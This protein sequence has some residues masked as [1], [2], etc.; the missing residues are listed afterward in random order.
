MSEVE[1]PP[2]AV[3]SAASS[4]MPQRRPSTEKF[5]ISV[6][7][8]KCEA[9]FLNNSRE[10]YDK[11]PD[12]DISR[13]GRGSGSS[14]RESEAD[15]VDVVDP[16]EAIPDETGAFAPSD[17]NKYLATPAVRRIITE[18][19]CDLSKIQGTGKDGRI[20]KEDVLA[21]LENQKEVKAGSKS[22]HLAHFLLC[23]H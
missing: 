16:Y 22:L 13:I 15:T 12:C 17:K 6:L 23:H 4:R 7:G 2:A 20:L 5:P 19:N 14:V 10:G 3:I 8:D 11:E 18:H 1:L 9:L 21:Y